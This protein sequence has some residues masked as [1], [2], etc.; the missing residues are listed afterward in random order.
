[1]KYIAILVAIAAA[2]ALSQL[3]FEF[4]DWNRT[5]SCVSAGGRNCDGGPVRLYH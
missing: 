1:M 5:Q 2:F 3:L 4:Y